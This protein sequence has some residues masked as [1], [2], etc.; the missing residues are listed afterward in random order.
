MDPNWSGVDETEI[1]L[2]D[3]LGQNVP[4]PFNPKTTIAYEVPAGGCHVSIK[5]VDVSGRVVRHLVDELQEEGRKEI[6]WDGRDDEGREL[7][8][9]VYFYTLTGADATMKRRLVL[10]RQ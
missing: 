1:P 8:S 2:R 4:N 7:S 6:T 5:I 10:L 3:G 9:G